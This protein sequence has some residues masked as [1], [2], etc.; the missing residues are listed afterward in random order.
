MAIGSF[1]GQVNIGSNSHAIGST[2][3]GTCN[4][5][6]TTP[7]KAVALPGFTTLPDGVTIHVYCATANSVDNITLA[8]GTTLAH[9]VSNPNGSVRWSAGSMMSFTYEPGTQT[10]IINSAQIDAS[11]ITI[12]ISQLNNLKLGNIYSTGQLVDGTNTPYANRLVITN[13]NG[14]IVPGATISD[15]INGT[16]LDNTGNWTAP[17]D[18]KYKLVA[19]ATAT[20]LANAAATNGNTYLNLVEDNA[21]LNAH[22]LVG[23][24]IEITADANGQITFAGKPGTVTSVRVRA[25]GPVVSSQSAAQTGTLDTTISLAA[26]YGDTQNPYTAK[27]ANLVLAS[28]ASGTA[29]T[30]EFRALVDADIP[31]TIARLD[32]PAFDGKPTAPTVADATDSST[33]IATTAFVA[34]AIASKL[35]ANN[36]MLFKGTIGTATSNTIT[37]LPTNN[38]QIGNTYRVVGNY[39]F[40]TGNNA[41]NCEDGDLIIAIKNGPATGSNIIP[42][43]WTV[44]QA[45]I[46]GGLF[47]GS[48]YTAGQLLVAGN[49]GAVS[50]SGYTIAAPTVGSIL[51]GSA[52]NAYSSLATTGASA[53][54][55][56]TLTNSGGSL[57]PSWTR[58]TSSSSLYVNATAAG[59]TSDAAVTSGSTY[60]HFYNDT[61]KQSTITLTG[62]GGTTI[63]ANGSKTITIKSKKYK[64]TG[65]ANAFTGLSLTYNNGSD[66]TTTV[67]A[68][69]AE[70]I[71]YVDSGILYIK[72]IKYSTTQVS[73]G[74]SEDNT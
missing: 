60:I 10:W 9:A 61:T 43:D 65:T 46:D 34:S 42:G 11:Q 73:T 55:V 17:S 36:A 6:E 12:D 57:I 24:N 33:N 59:A 22:K 25:T 14:L 70:Q 68:N 20:A 32:S 13:N 19:A 27:N 31:A 30:P 26:G 66:Q 21:V 3:F 71:G 16:F 69:S 1:I 64:T 2:L 49:S 8:V 7:A 40:G 45:N 74:V 62:S 56:L 53:G 38:Y 58:N 54:Y 23:T 48:T 72:S 52:T 39:T 18:T 47:Q 29:A 5:P 50:T 44:A 67:S 41:V 51:Y 15:T 37:S 4:T 63:T 28:P 35:A